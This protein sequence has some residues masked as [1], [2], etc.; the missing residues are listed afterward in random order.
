[1]SWLTIPSTVR[2]LNGELAHDDEGPPSSGSL[3]AYR[4]SWPST[5]AAAARA[6]G[7]YPIT[8]EMNRSEP[9]A[10]SVREL[11]AT[12]VAVR[13]VLRSRAISPKPSPGPRVATILPSPR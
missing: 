12:T 3:G 7:V 13:R 11:R 6:L 4:P 9:S 1:M 10:R 5:P 8:A 2:H